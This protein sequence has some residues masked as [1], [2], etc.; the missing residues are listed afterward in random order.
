MSD[1]A[2]R[3][4]TNSYLVA[5][6][7]RDAATACQLSGQGLGWP[8]RRDG[9]SARC[10]LT[11]IS[12]TICML[13]GARASLAGTGRLLAVGTAV[14]LQYSCNGGASA[15]AKSPEAGGKRDTRIL[16]EECAIDGP[17]AEKIDANGDGKPDVTLVREGGREV[18]RAVDLN[19]DGKIDSWTYFDANGQV[20]RRERDYD[21][22]G[23]IEEISIYQG[24]VLI[25]Q[26]RATNLTHRLDTWHYYKDGQ[27]TRTER[28]SDGDGVVDQ[29]WEYQSQKCPL[30]HSDVDGDGRPDPGATVDY[31]KVTGYVPPERPGDRR[32]TSP[33]FERPGTLPTELENKPAEGSE[34]PAQ[35]KPEPKK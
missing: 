15:G 1:L 26:H 11:W 30:I 27:L 23:R 32:P 9:T 14:L 22:D 5:G 34:P 21:R 35:P 20:R 12:M 8:R 29:W 6:V 4:P 3:A 18:C 10:E 13:R 19:F 2:E 17:G 7:R 16:H 25:E 33:T 31:C 24:G 28:D